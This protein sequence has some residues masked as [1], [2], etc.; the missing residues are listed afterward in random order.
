MGF[1]LGEGEQE[2]GSWTVNYLP[3]D[4]GRYTGKL[5]VTPS[6][7]LMDASFDTSLGGVLRQMVIVEGGHGYL[8]IPKASIAGVEVKSSMLSKRVVL[9]LQD[10]SKHTLDYGMLSVR[11]IAE[12]I[13]AR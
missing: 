2:L 10:G 9:T 8:E 6:R 7:L 3:P 12:A 5:V 1:A 11:K 13:E 4:G